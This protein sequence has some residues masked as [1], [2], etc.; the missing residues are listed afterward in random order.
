MGWPS[1]AWEGHKWFLRDP[2]TR[3]LPLPLMVL[4]LISSSLNPS[5]I[6]L[7]ITFSIV[8]CLSTYKFFAIHMFIY[9]HRILQFTKILTHTHKYL[10]AQWQE[11]ACQWRRWKRYWCNP[12]VGKSPWWRK[13]QPMPI[14]LPGESHG[15][16]SLTG[17]SPWRLEESDMTEVTEHTH[18]AHTIPPFSSV[19]I[20]LVN[21]FKHADRK[22]GTIP[23]LQV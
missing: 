4:T 14:F 1:L 3:S 16:G 10:V 9:L 7:I 17:Y 19:Y 12:W 18:K 15:Q 23:I 5:W 13:W 21:Y 20:L 22:N 2:L 6:P 11:S 8:L